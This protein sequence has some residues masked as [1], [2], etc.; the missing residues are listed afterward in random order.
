MSLKKLT[1]L[2]APAPATSAIAARWWC[3][4]GKMGKIGKFRWDM[5]WYAV[6]GEVEEKGP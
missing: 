6:G 4:W 2:K 1:T 5:G 3:C